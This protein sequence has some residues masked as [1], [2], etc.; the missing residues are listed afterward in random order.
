MVIDMGFVRVPV[1]IKN[2]SLSD[3]AAVAAVIIAISVWSA[4]V[5]L[6]KAPEG[7]GKSQQ[8]QQETTPNKW[9]RY[10]LEGFAGVWNGLVHGCFYG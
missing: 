7:G 1:R 3:E 6:G 2:V 10:K 8:S 9:R 5:G 4:A